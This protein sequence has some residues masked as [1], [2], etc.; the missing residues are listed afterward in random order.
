MRYVRVRFPDGET[1]FAWMISDNEAVM[2]PKAP[3][4]ADSSDRDSA[5]SEA[6]TARSIRLADTVRLAPVIPSKIIC[7]GRNYAAHAKEMG[8][9]VPK[10]PMLFFKP[11]SSVIAHG[12]AIE[13]PPQS[14]KVEHEAELGV[15]IGRR[16]KC[17]S[18]AEAKSHILGYTIVND[19]TARDLQKSDGQ[20]AR[21]KGFDTFCPVGPWLETELDPSDL[22]VICR[23]NGEVRQ[24][25][26]TKDMVFDV[27]ALVAYASQ[28]FTLEPGDLIVTGTPDGV[29]PLNPGDSLE[30]EISGIGVLK[31]GVV[32]RGEKAK[33]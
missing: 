2:M 13:L 31:N 3:W 5:S 17:I 20:W 32:A 4:E 21:A 11:P 15:V 14:R 30:T 1:S 29:G 16:A 12:E 19:V 7:V 33:K 25:G 24:N 26:S 22:K 18:A 10:E 28:I 9:E 6:P 8:N 27:A 23:V